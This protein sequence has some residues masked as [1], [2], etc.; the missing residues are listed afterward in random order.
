M[1]T[2]VTVGSGKTYSDPVTAYSAFAPGGYIMEM[3]PL[4]GGNEYINTGGAAYTFS[5]QPTSATDTATL[6][7][8]AG[9]SF[10]DNANKAT[11]A[12][13]YN[14]ANGI[15]IKGTANYD[16]AVHVG[17]E[18]FTINNLQIQEAGGNSNGPVLFENC[19]GTINFCIL[20]RNNTGAGTGVLRA[21]GFASTPLVIRNS[22]LEWL[23]GSA[24]E[25]F[26]HAQLCD[27]FSYFVTMVL[28]SD[29]AVALPCAVQSN[30]GAITLENCAAFAN[31]AISGGLLL[32]GGSA[33]VTTSFTDQSSPGTGW[34]N[35]TYSSQFQG[36]TKAA[37][38]WRTKTG[39]G[40]RGAGT[41]D[42]TNGAFDIL[43]TARPQAGN[44]DAG[45]FQFA[46]AGVV[47]RVIPTLLLMGVG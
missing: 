13:T 18:Y 1:T 4:A 8:G 17:D 27:I 14:A 33:S 12:L 16:Y 3:Y 19:G 46:S 23:N 45:A 15:S 21:F 38:D 35:L 24:S 26:I 32:A 11:N 5:G 42:S 41:A 22:I 43:G 31:N 10:N 37:P 28:A 30:Y 20:S 7:T 25:P 44:W 2:T 9:Q 34:T 29:N 39:S 47:V 6:Q 36:T 40:L